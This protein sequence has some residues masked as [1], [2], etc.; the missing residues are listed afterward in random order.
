M[1]K[2]IICVHSLSGVDNDQSMEEPGVDRDLGTG[3]NS[4]IFGVGF[5]AIRI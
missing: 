2:K 5:Q 4:K 3:T 1:K